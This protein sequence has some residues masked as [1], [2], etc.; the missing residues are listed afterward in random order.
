MTRVIFRIWRDTGAVLALFPDEIANMTGDCLSY[1]HV[2]QHG[3]ADY[4]ACI[5]R[6][7]LAQPAQFAAL[8][9]ELEAIGYT[10]KLGQRR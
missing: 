1:E 5:Q 7:R 3:A 4:N 8:K 10:L 2:G 9:R 6:T